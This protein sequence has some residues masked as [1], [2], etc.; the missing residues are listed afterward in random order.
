MKSMDVRANYSDHTMAKYLT[1]KN[2]N[3]DSVKQFSNVTEY[4][5]RNGRLIAVMVYKDSRVVAVY[6]D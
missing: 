6:T 4:Y 2:V 3:W 1:S 5:D